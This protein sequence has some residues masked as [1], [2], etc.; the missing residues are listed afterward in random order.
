MRNTENKSLH[1]FSR[2]TLLIT[3]K[4]L[5]A[6]VLA[7]SL[8]SAIVGKANYSHECDVKAY[9]RKLRFIFPVIF[10]F[11]SIHKAGSHQIYVASSLERDA[12]GELK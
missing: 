1:L 10:R 11:S 6:V 5:Y 3:W 4:K 9:K 8:L 7:L 2:K 12:K